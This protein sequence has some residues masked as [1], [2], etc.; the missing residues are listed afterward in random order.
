MLMTENQARSIYTGDIASEIIDPAHEYSTD[1]QEITFTDEQHAIWAELFA[2]IHQPY[3]LEHICQ[4]F[5]KGLALLQLD[6]HRIPTLV[7]ILP[8]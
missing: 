2:G 1:T 6:Q 3:L 5:L 8:A 7:A 4:E